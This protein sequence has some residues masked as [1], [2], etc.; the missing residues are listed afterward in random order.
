M[1]NAHD[2]SASRQVDLSGLCFLLCI[3]VETEHVL[4]TMSNLLGMSSGL[5]PVLS[6]VISTTKQKS[7]TGTPNSLEML[8]AWHL[9]CYQ[10]RKRVENLNDGIAMQNDRTVERVANEI[11]VDVA[12]PKAR[13][14]SPRKP[15]TKHSALDEVAVVGGRMQSAT[16]SMATA[17]LPLEGRF[18]NAARAAGRHDMSY[19]DP[20]GMF[21]CAFLFHG[22]LHPYNFLM[23]FTIG[24]LSVSIPGKG[25]LYR[26]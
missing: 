1:I 20:T 16:G 8:A 21:E 7:E 10:C 11:E 14:Q 9:Q 24:Q 25:R 19:T 22:F 6:L 23:G 5:R 18:G 26:C 15:R 13:K 17:P 3:Q 12:V 2:G 4:L